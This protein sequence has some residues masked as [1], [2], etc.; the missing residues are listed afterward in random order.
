[1]YN[2]FD[3]RKKALDRI[4]HLFLIKKPHTT[5][6]EKRELPETDEGH[7]GQNHSSRHA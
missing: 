4:Q 2:H 7:L 6:R 1:M 3:R 5:K